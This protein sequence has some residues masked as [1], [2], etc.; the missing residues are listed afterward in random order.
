ME[1]GNSQRRSGIHVDS[2]GKVKFAVGKGENNDGECESKRVEESHEG[3]GNT[4]KYNDDHRGF[5]GCQVNHIRWSGA[6]YWSVRVHKAH[7]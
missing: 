3:D 1:A 7:F 2:A 5:G 4:F 6:H